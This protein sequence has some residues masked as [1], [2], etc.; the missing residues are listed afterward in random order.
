M[1]ANDD[2]SDQDNYAG[3]YGGSD[4]VMEEAGYDEIE[5]E[6]FDYEEIEE[7]EEFDYDEE[8]YLFEFDPFEFVEYIYPFKDDSDLEIMTYQSLL[9]LAKKTCQLLSAWKL[10]KSSSP[11]ETDIGSIDDKP[12]AAAH[13]FG[14][15]M[16]QICDEERDELK[17]Y[18]V[19]KLLRILGSEDEVFNFQ[20]EVNQVV[21]FLKNCLHDILESCLPP[22]PD[23]VLRILFSQLLGVKGLQKLGQVLEQVP[24]KMVEK[25]YMNKL[26]LS[27]A[28]VYDHLKVVMFNIPNTDSTESTL[29]EKKATFLERFKLLAELVN[30]SSHEAYLDSVEIENA[31]VADP[32][33]EMEILDKIEGKEDGNNNPHDQHTHICTAYGFCASSQSK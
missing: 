23:P 20:E 25:D 7:E 16:Y 31:L 14:L 27:L 2:H 30:T 9:E 19:A 28:E 15:N 11:N 29:I 3:A 24:I 1:S 8:T 17:I 18:S 22:L 32:G 10:R 21:K 5:E 13:V 4:D 26:Y 6:I 12:L 33:G